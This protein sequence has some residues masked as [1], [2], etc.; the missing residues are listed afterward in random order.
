MDESLS[1]KLLP[2]GGVFTEA[3]TIYG[4]I[5][6][7]GDQCWGYFLSNNASVTTLVGLVEQAKAALMYETIENLHAE[8][9]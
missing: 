2:E 4:Y 7:E 5:D 8:E 3:I 6:P 1:Q 9:D